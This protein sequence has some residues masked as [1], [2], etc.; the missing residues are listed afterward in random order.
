LVAVVRVLGDRRNAAD[1]YERTA[2]HFRIRGTRPGTP[3][4]YESEMTA[5]E[6][7]LGPEDRSLPGVLVDVALVAARAAEEE[8]ARAL[9][10]RSVALAA[11]RCG[12]EHP[13]LAEPLAVL[14]E[15]HDEAG[16]PDLALPLMERAVR[17]Y[18]SWLGPA[19]PEVAHGL[20]SLAKLH[21][22]LGRPDEALAHTERAVAVLERAG[23]RADLFGAAMPRKLAELRKELAAQ[24]RGGAPGTLDRA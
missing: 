5:V 8:T 19:A 2:D 7:F 13:I 10:E 3:A 23:D 14:A 11:K 24:W 17:V 16:R 20:F 6:R 12:P 22:A 9:V 18:L 4:W 21:R 1:L 15:M